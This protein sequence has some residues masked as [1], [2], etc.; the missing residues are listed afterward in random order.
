MQIGCHDETWDDQSRLGDL[1][2]FS[3][4]TTREQTQEPRLVHETRGVCI[5]QVDRLSL[6]QNCSNG[7]P[8]G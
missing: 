2:V 8:S 5:G 6:V 1:L 7:F 4:T 3:M